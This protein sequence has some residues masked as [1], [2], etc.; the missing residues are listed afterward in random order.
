MLSD[1][2]S[3]SCD[4]EPPLD[5]VFAVGLSS[6]LVELC[7][8]VVDERGVDEEAVVASEVELFSGVDW[9]E[10]GG[11]WVDEGFKSSDRSKS[12]L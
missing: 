9:V 8:A 1:L 4:W 10:S 11:G 6:G 3:R 7:G 12:S 2:E 5:W